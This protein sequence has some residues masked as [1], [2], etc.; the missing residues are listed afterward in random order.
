MGIKFVFHLSY[1][2]FVKDLHLNL[3]LGASVDVQVVFPDRLQGF[4][5]HL[6]RFM[7]TQE[8]ISSCSNLC[9]IALVFISDNNVR[10]CFSVDVFLGQ[11]L[12]PG[13]LKVN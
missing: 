8:D 9:F 3:V 10:I 1:L 2:V 13:K 5:T 6:S 4:L 12:S 7:S 11:I